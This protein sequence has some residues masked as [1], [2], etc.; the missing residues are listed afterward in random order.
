VCF[1][2]T[3]HRSHRV[4][5]RHPTAA[6]GE[7]RFRHT[8]EIAHYLFPRH[9]AEIDRLD[10]QHYVFREAL[11]AN[12]VA[13]VEEP[14]RVLD[15]GCGT[16][17]WAFEVCDQFPDALVVGLDL[18]ASKPEPPLRY[19][20][21]NGNVLQGLPFAPARFDLVHQRLLVAAVPVASWPSLVAD[22]VRVAR[23]GGWVELVEV[24]WKVERAGPATERLLALTR[25]MSASR[26]LDATG[27]V[28]D[29]V[30]GYLRKAGLV[31]VERREI[32]CPLGQ[33][34]GQM[35]S[36]GATDL[37]AAFTRICEVLQAQSKLSPDEGRHLIQQA[38]DECER[39]R[40][41]WPAAVA[42]GRKPR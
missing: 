32:S 27:A 33:W 4:P 18:V 13:P 24:A 12:F 26:G 38:H 10:I 2:H 22:L 34:G 17:Q 6:R 30:D 41:A 37:R 40:M 1:A 9:P 39:G 3:R 23:P 8:N 31:N 35:G 28:F 19:R 29:S 14:R 36:L 7:R 5:G 20:W 15:V 25:E 11:G 16:G 21:V 42:F